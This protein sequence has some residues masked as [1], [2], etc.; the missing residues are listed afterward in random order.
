[1]SLI[2][3][4]CKQEIEISLRGLYDNLSEHERENKIVELLAE[5]LRKKALSKIDE[6]QNNHGK[7]AQDE[8]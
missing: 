4:D 3:S 7:P 6:Q 8:D 5:M 1:M 2:I